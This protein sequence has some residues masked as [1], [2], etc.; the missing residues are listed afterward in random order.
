MP[1]Y[2]AI[3]DQIIERQENYNLPQNSPGYL[4][5]VAEH[6]WLQTVGGRALDL[7]CGAGFVL[8]YLSQPPFQL[9]MWGA[10][11]SEVAVTRSLTRLRQ[12]RPDS[13]P[14]RVQ[15]IVDAQLPYESEFFGLVTCFDVLEHLDERDIDRTWAEILRVL[16]RG[17]MFFGSVSCRPSG[18]V[19][20]FGDNLHRTVR[21]IDWWLG[22]LEPDRLE[23]H[24]DTA[25]LTL[26]KRTASQPSRSPAT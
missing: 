5:C 15:R 16:R 6:R 19:D 4:S 14:E 17:G 23:Y 24:R 8:E 7:G 13:G 2:R 1:D 25:Q 3:Y 22:R 12:Q 11:V 20:Q 10:D 9:E 26:W 21:S 18:S